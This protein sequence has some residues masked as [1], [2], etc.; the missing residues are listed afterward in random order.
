[1]VIEA[2]PDGITTKR[3][4]VIAADLM[5]WAAGVKGAAFMHEIGG[6]ETTRG[7]QIVVRP[8]LQTTRDDRIFALGDCASYIPSGA[9]RPVPPRPRQPTRWPVSSITISGR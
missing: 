3:G 8:T 2:R 5:V 9:T 7:N 6:L 4:D 1:M